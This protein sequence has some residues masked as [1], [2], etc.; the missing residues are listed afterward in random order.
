MANVYLM[1][2]V[3]EIKGT[4][5]AKVRVFLDQ[6]AQSSFVSTEPVEAIK[7]PCIGTKK[8]MVQPFWQSADVHDG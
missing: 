5:R 7:P 1:T 2:A 3:A 8:L 6:G 4:K